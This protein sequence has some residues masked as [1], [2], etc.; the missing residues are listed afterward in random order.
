MESLFIYALSLSLFLKVLLFC[1][2]QIKS[3]TKKKKN[4]SGSDNFAEM[5]QLSYSFML[6]A[7]KLFSC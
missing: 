3:E 2:L 1:S 6:K 5:P 7:Y 4:H